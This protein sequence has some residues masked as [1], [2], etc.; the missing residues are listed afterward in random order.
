[1]MLQ[2]C[3]KCGCLTRANT[4]ECRKCAEGAA[5]SRRRELAE[6]NRAA[7]EWALVGETKVDW[8]QPLPSSEADHRAARMKEGIDD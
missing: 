4:Q 8:L 7:L 2:N 6:K 5:E 3:P 1:M